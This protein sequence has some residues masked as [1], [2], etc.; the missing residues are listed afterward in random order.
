MQCRYVIA[1]VAKNP[2]TLTAHRTLY[3]HDTRVYIT[4]TLL[5][6]LGTILALLGV[7]LT[8]LPRS[9]DSLLP[10]RVIASGLA[11]WLSW[12]ALRYSRTEVDLA[13]E[14]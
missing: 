14:V 4:V 13:Y 8:P 3:Y 12:Y 9:E 10:C 2:C 11:C 6:R 1:L 5:Q 7:H